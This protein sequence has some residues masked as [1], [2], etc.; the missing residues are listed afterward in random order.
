MPTGSKPSK[1]LLPHETDE[2]VHETHRQKPLWMLLLLL[3][4]K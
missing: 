1:G 3:Y 4:L 2:V